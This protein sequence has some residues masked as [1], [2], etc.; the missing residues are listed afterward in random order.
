MDEDD[1]GTVTSRSKWATTRQN[2]A[3]L[4][5][6]VQG[7]S[8]RSNWHVVGQ[9]LPGETQKSLDRW[10]GTRQNQLELLL[11]IKAK[12]GN[13]ND[14]TP[15]VTKT[16][17]HLPGEMNELKLRSGNDHLWAATRQNQVDLLF[18]IQT[19]LPPPKL[20]IEKNEQTYVKLSQDSE[21][22][23]IHEAKNLKLGGRKKNNAIS[24]DVDNPLMQGD[25]DGDET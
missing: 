22:F 21:H 5:A 20:K 25:E 11:A 12:A 17:T 4:L 8:T 16:L 6:A 14:G 3:E 2:Q 24:I 23:R 1:D 18:A 9:S 19:A 13:H 15:K 7:S 10:A